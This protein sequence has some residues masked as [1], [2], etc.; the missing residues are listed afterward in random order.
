VKKSSVVQRVS[1]TLPR[2]CGNSASMWSR[3]SSLV[4]VS[5]GLA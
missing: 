1:D 3:E 2:S 4:V 5:D